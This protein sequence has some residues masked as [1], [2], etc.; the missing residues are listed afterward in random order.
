[1]N[2]LVM[3]NFTIGKVA[4]AADVNVETIRFYERK[5]LIKQ[6]AT[7]EGSYRIYPPEVVPRIRFIQRAKQLG[8]SLD[9]VRALL[10]LADRPNDKRVSAIS[11]AEK[12]LED[13][14]RRLS[15]LR[16]MQKTLK[17]FLE[18]CAKR[19]VV[20]G[21]RIIETLGGDVD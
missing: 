20:V 19:E 12:N 4:K 14:D 18:S 7:Y 13:I 2:P 6:P 15:D 3:E 5:G 8:F 11:I 17:D 21:F 10:A 1:M 9:E 16:R